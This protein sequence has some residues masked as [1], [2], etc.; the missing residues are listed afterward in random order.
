MKSNQG[1][2][3]YY[4][5]KKLDTTKK[6][7]FGAILRIVP[8]EAVEDFNLDLTLENSIAGTTVTIIE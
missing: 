5:I 7:T 1:I 2:E 8:T 6:A 3:D 4:F